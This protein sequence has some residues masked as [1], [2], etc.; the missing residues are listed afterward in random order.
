MV[1]PADHGGSRKTCMGQADNDGHKGETQMVYMADND[2]SQMSRKQ[3]AN[4][5]QTDINGFERVA[6]GSKT[7]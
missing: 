7:C 6:N 2:V 3:V 1:G 5:S 4:R